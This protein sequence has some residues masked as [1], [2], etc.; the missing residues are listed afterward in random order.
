M[1]DRDD[2]IL[3]TLQGLQSG[4]NDSQ[5]EAA[6]V[7]AIVE[8][9]KEDIQTIQRERQTSARLYQEL[10]DR[11]V[12]TESDAG[13]ALVRQDSWERDNKDLPTIRTNVETLMTAASVR[14]SRVWDVVSPIISAILTAGLMWLVFRH[15]A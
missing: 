14:T 4:L 6:K 5:R 2:L 15:P 13:R 3:Q 8:R 9:A 12:A 1:P 11:V 10:R 7:A